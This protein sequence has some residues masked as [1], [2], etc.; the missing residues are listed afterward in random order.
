MRISLRTARI[1]WFLLGVAESIHVL[2]SPAQHSLWPVFRKGALGWWDGRILYTG[3]DYFRYSPVFAT[4]LWPL[5]A[6]P[7]VAGNILFDLGGLA[8]LF[9]ATRRLAR[10]VFPAEVLSRNEPAVLVLSLAGVI[11]SAWSSQSHAWSA[12]LV[13]LAAASLVEERWWAA[14]V[15]LALA[16]HLKL[17]PMALAGVVAVLWPRKMSGRLLLALGAWTALPWV[18]GRPA[19][20]LNIY[21]DWLSRLGTL[22]TLRL[23]GQRDL[24]HIFELGSVRVPLIAYRGLQFFGGLLVLLWALRLRRRGADA[25]W[26]V[27]GAFAVTIAYM[28]AMGPAVEFVQYPL[29]APWVSGAL[30]AT[31][32]RSRERF[33]L[34]LIYAATMIAGWG[35]V[36]DALGRLMGSAVSESLITLGTIAFGVWVILTWRRA[37]AAAARSREPGYPNATPWVDLSV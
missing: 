23:P 27:S 25:V 20:V 24:L 29:L 30:L 35:A 19:R 10:I 8:L 18:A 13:F 11:R 7:G 17:S 32:R 3:P 26:T 14:A 2:V 1:L 37:P 22:T 21:R 4:L 31:G 28:L 12:A 33:A 34:A 15:A 36:E 6:L 16:V 5:A 9:H